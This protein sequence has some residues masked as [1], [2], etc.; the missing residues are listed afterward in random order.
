MGCGAGDAYLFCNAVRVDG[1][2]GSGCMRG[3]RWMRVPYFEDHVRIILVRFIS[4]L[5]LTAELYC[6]NVRHELS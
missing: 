5:H 4:S 6:F 3:M 2:K 1:A